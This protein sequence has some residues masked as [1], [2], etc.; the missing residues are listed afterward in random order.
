VLDSRQTSILILI[1]DVL[2]KGVDRLVDE[3]KSAGEYPVEF[4]ASD[5]SSGL[6]ICYMRGEGFNQSRKLLYR[7]NTCVNPYNPSLQSGEQ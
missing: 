4:N 3:E 2:G 7:S 5:L 6:Y 1:Y